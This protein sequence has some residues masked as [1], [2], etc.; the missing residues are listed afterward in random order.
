MVANHARKNASRARRAD[1][2]GNHRQAVDAVR[3]EQ[4]AELIV[5]VPYQRRGSIEPWLSVRLIMGSGLCRV[6]A[7]FDRREHD[8]MARDQ[9]VPSRGNLRSRTMT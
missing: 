7:R 8:G 6:M 1:A 2:G 5:F 9:Q 3:A 4:G